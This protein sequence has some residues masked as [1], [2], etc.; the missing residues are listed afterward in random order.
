MVLD[1]LFTDIDVIVG[2]SHFEILRLKM[3]VVSNK[4]LNSEIT[5]LN[6]SCY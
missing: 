5:N 3:R 1:D 2:F 4:P 6:I